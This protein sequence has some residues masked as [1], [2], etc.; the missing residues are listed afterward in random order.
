MI[1]ESVLR[2]SKDDLF[3]QNTVWCWHRNFVM[4]QSIP[5]T[6]SPWK[7]TV[8]G[9]P[10]FI[11]T[12][13]PFFP[14]P[15]PVVRHCTDGTWLLNLP[16]RSVFGSL[17]GQQLALERFLDCSVMG[18]LLTEETW[19]GEI[20]AG[21]GALKQSGVFGVHVQSSVVVYLFIKKI[22]QI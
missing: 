15:K 3:I 16:V 4:V 1:V 2:E 19:F 14:T 10:E 21:F 6:T 18:T 22:I 5:D 17:F 13:M 12:E 7:D 20:F 8:L 11:F 9:C